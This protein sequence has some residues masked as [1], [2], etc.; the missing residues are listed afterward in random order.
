MTTISSGGITFNLIYDQAATSSPASFRQ[1][2]EQAASILA[3][4]ITDK[5]TVNVKIDYSGTGGNPLNLRKN[6]VQIWQIV[7]EYTL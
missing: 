7:I 5:I 4:I 2:I 1:G 6:H 3:A